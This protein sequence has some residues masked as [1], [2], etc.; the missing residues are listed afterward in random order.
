MS[1]APSN[2]ASNGGGVKRRRWIWIVLIAS[3][4]LNLLFVGFMAGSWWRHGGPGERHKIITGA[5]EK[6]MQDLPQAKKDHA[7]ALLKRHRETIK[8]VRQQIREAKNA[9]K[10]AL[11]T[12][13]YDEE[14]VKAA[15]LRFREIRALRH[16]SQHRML[17]DLLKELNLEEREKL[18]NNIRAGFRAR[19]RNR[20][21]SESGSGQSN[22][23]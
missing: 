9:A 15:L 22:R 3:L 6:L 10:E 19:W 14:K 8:P 16:E 23:P 7:A 12:E 1:A 2:P 21:R 17:L 18:L 11:L 4:A 20:A 5:V 13:P